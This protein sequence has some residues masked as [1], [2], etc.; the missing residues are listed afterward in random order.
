MAPFSLARQQCP[1]TS[2]ARV[3]AH[4]PGGAPLHK[5]LRKPLHKPLQ[6][7]RKNLPFRVIGPSFTLT[8]PSQHGKPR[9]VIK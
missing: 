5:R 8:A 2:L 7:L 9:Q 1:H 4:P 3:F 6:K